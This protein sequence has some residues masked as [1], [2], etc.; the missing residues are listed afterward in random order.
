MR[1]LFQHGKDPTIGDK[2]LGPIAELE[3]DAVGARYAVP[4][5]DT[6]Y[7]RELIPGLQAGLYD[8]SFRFQVVREEFVARPRRSDYNPKGFAEKSAG[9]VER[10]FGDAGPLVIRTPA[11]PI[12]LTGARSVAARLSAARRRACAGRPRRRRARPS[13][14][15]RAGRPAGL[16]RC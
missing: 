8:A 16:S 14:P 9:V 4:L 2:P 12:I 13:R 10:F 6:S 11:L 7:N 1:V 15:C 3:A 5:L